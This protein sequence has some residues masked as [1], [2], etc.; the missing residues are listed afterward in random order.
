MMIMITA[1]RAYEANVAALNAAKA[2][3]MKTL[4]IGN[5]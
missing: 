5:G 2:M 1:V 4:D 3:A